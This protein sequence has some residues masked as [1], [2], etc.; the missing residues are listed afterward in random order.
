M[1]SPS[2]LFDDR[3]GRV[4]P[5]R[6]LHSVLAVL[7]MLLALAPQ[8]ARAD[9]AEV[10]AVMDDIQKAVLK[11][12]KTS[13]IAHVATDDAIF[14]KEQQNWAADFDHHVPVEYTI[15]IKDDEGTFEATESKFQMTT[16]WKMG[17]DV[18]RAPSRKL[19]FPVVFKKIEGQ[20]LYAGE[21][22]LV[23]EAP[24]VE[25]A[26]GARVKFYAGAEKR[27]QTIVSVLPEVRVHVD[28]GFDVKID[29]VQEVKVYKS[30]LHLQHSIYLSYVDDLGGWNEPGE[31]I[32]VL[33]YEIRGEKATKALLAH[34]YGHVCTFEYGDKTSDMPWWVL[35]GVAELASEEYRGDADSTD[36]LV[37]MWAKYDELAP[38]ADIADFRTTD[39]KKWGAN[40]YKQGHHML[41]YIS[42]KFGKESRIKWLKTMAKGKTIDEASKEVL[43]MTFDE[44]DKQWRESVTEK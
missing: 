31:S 21:D 6:A 33:S 19:T 27:S 29:R 1:H 13:Y 3:S 32:K 26:A 2:L 25:G 44:L 23:L 20:W 4:T 17:E 10:R 7:A 42:E 12:D 14:L 8:S 5:K 9:K 43:K 18:R 34:E 24:G 40:V 11:G 16:E 22:W 36:A 39:Q 15:S 38:W 41:G 35:E 37:K 28:K 30:M